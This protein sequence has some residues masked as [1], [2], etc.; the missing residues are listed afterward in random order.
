MS[1]SYAATHNISIMR[2]HL[3]DNE[4]KK[5]SAYIIGGAR[6]RMQF[7]RLQGIILH[8]ATLMYLV[9]NKNDAADKANA[10]AKGN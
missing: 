9:S 4:L 10:I 3:A 7:G 1:D 8:S 5:I 6:P 2:L